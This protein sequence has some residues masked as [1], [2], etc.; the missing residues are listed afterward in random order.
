MIL[1]F[2]DGERITT[3]G[4]P[5]EFLYH[6]RRDKLNEYLEGLEKFNFQFWLIEQ[7]KKWYKEVQN[8]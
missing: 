6:N 8:G 2:S 1:V 4:N 3:T 5:T 7:H